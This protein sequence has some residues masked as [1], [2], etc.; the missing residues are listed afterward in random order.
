MPLFNLEDIFDEHAF[1]GI[2]V[3]KQTAHLSAS[4]RDA[5]VSAAALERSRQLETSGCV[6]DGAVNTDMVAVVAP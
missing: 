6:G 4:C 3:V 1:L 2:P 5:A